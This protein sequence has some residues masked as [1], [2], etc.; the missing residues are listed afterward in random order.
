[1]INTLKKFLGLGPKINYAELIKQGA[2]IL[3]V[4]SKDEFASGHIIGSINISVDQLANNLTKLKDKNKP[5]ITCCASGMRS[6]M[7]KNVLKSNGYS[8]VYNGGGWSSLQGKL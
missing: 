4:R 6:A 7:A 3:D 8:Q 2:V 5:I 1:M